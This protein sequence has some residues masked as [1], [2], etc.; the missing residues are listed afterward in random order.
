MKSQRLFKDTEMRENKNSNKYM[1]RMNKREL[2]L[3][4]NPHSNK[5]EMKLEEQVL[6]TATEFDMS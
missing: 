6:S 3:R 2:D 1:T 5:K 4:T